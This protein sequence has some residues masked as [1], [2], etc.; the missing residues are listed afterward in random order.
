MLPEEQPTSA[1]KAKTVNPRIAIVLDF[2]LETSGRPHAGDDPRSI[3]ELGGLHQATAI[4]VGFGM[5][6]GEHR[7]VD[8]VDDSEVHAVADVRRASSIRSLGLGSFST[9]RTGHSEVLSTLHVVVGSNPIDAIGEGSFYAKT[10]PK[11]PHSAFRSHRC[12]CNLVDRRLG[13]RWRAGRCD[14]ARIAQATAA[15]GAR[16]SDAEDAR[17]LAGLAVANTAG[18]RTDRRVIHVIVSSTKRGGV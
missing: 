7:S 13:E 17:I 3:G 2:N 14:G 4:V 18:E 9:V 6:V 5:A 16:A 15:V 12:I 8:A 1:E 10:H 11:V